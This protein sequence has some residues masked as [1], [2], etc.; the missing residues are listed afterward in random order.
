ML[1]KQK[2]IID[3]SANSSIS[4]SISGLLE[5]SRMYII[6]P[7]QGQRYMK[8]TSAYETLIQR[9][10]MSLD[11]YCWFAMAK[12]YIVAVYL[13]PHSSWLILRVSATSRWVGGAQLFSMYV[14]FYWLLLSLV[15]H[16]FQTTQEVPYRWLHLWCLLVRSDLKSIH[17]FDGMPQHRC[18]YLLVIRF[19]WQM[20]IYI[21]I[22]TV[23][24]LLCFQPSDNSPSTTSRG[25][26]GTVLR[27]LSHQFDM[28]V[29]FIILEEY[30]LKVSRRVWA[31]DSVLI[32]L[33]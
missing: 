29:S 4:E 16:E 9:S 10:L 33:S 8:R 13:L 7:K 27:R 18:Y 5:P 20:K 6:D 11:L 19:T 14:I 17:I 26:S 30:I 32:F 3:L 23:N 2:K 28:N 22:S 25:C 21:W 24:C 1:T 31:L 12:L 15:T